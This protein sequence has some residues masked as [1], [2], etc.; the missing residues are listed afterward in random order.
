MKPCATCKFSGLCL[1]TSFNEVVHT[2]IT[3]E[4]AKLRRRKPKLSNGVTHREAVRRV[5]N[6]LLNYRPKEC[7]HRSRWCHESMHEM[8]TQRAVLI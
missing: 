5:M 8:Q 3:N 7:T 6:T 4:A 2:L 1:S